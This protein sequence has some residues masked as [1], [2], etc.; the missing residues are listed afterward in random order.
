MEKELEEWLRQQEHTAQNQW[1]V[2]AYSECRKLSG[3]L[4][5]I[6]QIEQLVIDAKKNLC[7]QPTSGK[8]TES[9][10]LC[11][12]IIAYNRVLNKMREMA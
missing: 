5:I 2:D 10:A 9:T 4:P 7:R 3:D 12:A 6:L 11:F 8:T 1:T